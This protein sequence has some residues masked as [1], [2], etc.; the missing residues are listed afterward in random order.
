MIQEVKNSESKII[1]SMQ[2]TQ[3]HFEQDREQRDDVED[4][5]PTQKANSVAT[6]VLQFE[7]L[8]LLKEI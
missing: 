7:I 5:N 1:R 3:E 2:M 6:D 8:Q 4:F